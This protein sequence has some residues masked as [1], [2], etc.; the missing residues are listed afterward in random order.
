MTLWTKTVHSYFHIDRTN[1]CLVKA[2][3][4]FYVAT[5]WPISMTLSSYVIVP[6][7]V[8]ISNPVQELWG[9]LL[10]VALSPSK[11]LASLCNGESKLY[12]FV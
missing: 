12:L 4:M 3:F 9:I 10:K 2:I 1:V 5:K 6:S 11:V 8:K 7:L